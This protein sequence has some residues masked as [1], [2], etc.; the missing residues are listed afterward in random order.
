MQ[1]H[2]HAKQPSQLAKHLANIFLQIIGNKKST[3]TNQQD[4]PTEVIKN[5]IH[6]QGEKKIS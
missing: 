3:L 6:K 4:I 2:A 1:Y 5:H